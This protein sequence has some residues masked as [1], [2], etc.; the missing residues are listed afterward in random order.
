[1]LRC[2]RER[3]RDLPLALQH[4]GDLRR[5]PQSQN[6]RESIEKYDDPGE[7]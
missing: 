6:A 4:L 5:E 3:L 2:L 7:G 1:M